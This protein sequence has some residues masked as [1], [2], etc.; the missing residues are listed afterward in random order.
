MPLS[1]Q[2]QKILNVIPE[3][4]ARPFDF[5]QQRKSFKEEIRAVTT[6][7][8]PGLGEEKALLLKAAL[9]LYFDSFDEA[10]QIAQDHEGLEGN[11]I[12]AILHRREPDAGNSKYWYRRVAFPPEISKNINEKALQLL[13]ENPLSELKGLQKRLAA[14]KA[15]EP[16]AFVDQVETFRAKD[17]VTPSY[18]L[19]A[20]IQEVEWRVLLRHL[21]TQGND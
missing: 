17:P 8:I 10:H 16:E 2:I 21:Q 5:L 11:W 20:Q 1:N 9:Y 15:W 12:H 19:L 18:R 7:D 14:S 4:Q 3:G 6:L 13:E